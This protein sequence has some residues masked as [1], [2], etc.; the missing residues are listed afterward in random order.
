MPV[1]VGFLWA[2]PRY[3]GCSVAHKRDPLSDE[4]R[5]IPSLRVT[6]LPDFQYTGLALVYRPLLIAFGSLAIAMVIAY[7]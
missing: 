1:L 2:S 6:A 4:N 7:I 3:S 5:S